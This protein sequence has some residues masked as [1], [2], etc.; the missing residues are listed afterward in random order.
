MS[1]LTVPLAQLQFPSACVECGAPPVRTFELTVPSAGPVARRRVP[2]PVCDRCGER[3]SLGQLAWTAGAAALGVGLVVAGAGTADALMP[4]LPVLRQTVAPI[5]AG[6]LVLGSVP[7]WLALRRGRL[8]YHRRFSAVWFQAYGAEPGTVTLGLRSPEL[9]RRIAV[10]SG[11]E[12][13]GADPYRAPPAEGGFQ[14][15]GGQNPLPSWVAMLVGL[16]IMGAGI[17]EYSM[18]GRAEARHE[19][20]RRVWLEIL[21]YQVGGRA[22][23]LGLF[24][25][26]GAALVALGARAFVKRAVRG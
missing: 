3:K 25:L 14:H 20:I 17:S 5:T 4:V 23:V 8:S 22:A 11:L 12:Q 18:I 7:V 9:R 15:P 10:C 1:P 6:L 19:A 26:I 13:S 16:G 2:V 24:L 21:V